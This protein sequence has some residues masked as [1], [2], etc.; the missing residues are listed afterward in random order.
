M[1]IAVEILW[2]PV[3]VGTA[4]GGLFYFCVHCLMAGIQ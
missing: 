1:R 3:V 2:L 4:I